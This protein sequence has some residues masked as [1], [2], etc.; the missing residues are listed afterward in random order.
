MTLNQSRCRPEQEAQ[1]GGNNN[2]MPIWR[3]DQNEAS[4]LDEC[5]EAGHAKWH[6]EEAK[7]LPSVEADL[8]RTGACRAEV[9]ST[10]DDECQTD[11][12][13]PQ[14]R[15]GIEVS[16]QNNQIP[17]QVAPQNQPRS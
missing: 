6:Q 7:C 17:D 12:G 14:P 11:R 8:Y 1:A 13:E 2:F 9:Q 10:A 4:I 5:R 15:V 3:K 16:D